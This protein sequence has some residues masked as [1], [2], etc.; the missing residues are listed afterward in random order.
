M[1][2]R[3][4]TVE[5]DLIFKTVDGDNL[6]LEMYRPVQGGLKP[7]V[8]VVHGGG[9]TSR[10]GDMRSI[11]QEIA[12]AGFIAIN[13]TY[14]L[15]PETHFPKSVEDVKDAIAW[16]KAN[17]EKYEIDPKNISGWGYSAGSN[18]ILLA[19]LDPKEGLRAIVAGGTPAD[20]TAWPDSPLVYKFLGSSLKEKPELWKQASPVNFVKKGSPRV[21]LYHGED[22]TLVE[23]DQMDK[24]AQALKAKDVP[25]ETLRIKSLGHIMVYFLDQKSVDQGIRFL[26]EN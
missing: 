2:A 3:T 24:M 22:D 4:Y 21:F 6:R 16:V 7:A 20:L 11:C 14:R 9:W 18:L 15:A 1:K 19:G 5:K 23:I 13:I 12:A 17:A 8:I 26:K 10:T 25:V